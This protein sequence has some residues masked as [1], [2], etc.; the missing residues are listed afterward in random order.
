MRPA[1]AK[2]AG[3]S[4]AFWVLFCSAIVVTFDVFAVWRTAR[5]YSTVHYR[6]AEGRVTLSEVESNI[7]GESTAFFPKIE[8][9]YAVAGRHYRGSRYRY[10]TI[11]H[12][13]HQETERIVQQHA[14]GSI[15]KVYYDPVNPADSLL[16]PGLDG[17]D[18]LL[19]LFLAPLNVLVAAWVFI[20]KSL[21]AYPRPV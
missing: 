14:Q 16:K 5:Q 8:Y 4:V 11:G 20:A 18:F 2:M 10:G 3:R 7:D 17:S 9:D 13:S 12:P 1:H 6:A 19:L 15:T 21:V